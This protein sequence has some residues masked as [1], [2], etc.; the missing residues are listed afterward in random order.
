MFFLNFATPVK[1]I[2]ATIIIPYCYSYVIITATIIYVIKVG[3]LISQAP[4]STLLLLMLPKVASFYI[5]LDIY[6]MLALFI[7]YNIYFDVNVYVYEL[8]LIKTV[9][10]CCFSIKDFILV[11]SFLGKY[12]HLTK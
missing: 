2:I 5:S 6:L 7:I 9:L 1:L 3:I 8:V 11:I 4:L 10:T 12:S